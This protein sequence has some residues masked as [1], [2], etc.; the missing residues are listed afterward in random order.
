MLNSRR[1]KLPANPGTDRATASTDSHP[2]CLPP[3]TLLCRSRPSSSSYLSSRPVTSASL[4]RPESGL[5]NR[6]PPPGAFFAARNTYLRA[7]GET[8]GYMRGT[9]QKNGREFVLGGRR[10]SRSD[11]AVCSCSRYGKRR[12]GR[13]R[14]SMCAEFLCRVRKG[15]VR[16]PGPDNRQ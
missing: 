14:A 15:A 6:L 13:K 2:S 11:A 3:T 7:E 8:P 4:R 16:S 12:R 9:K 10:A 1:K 5:T